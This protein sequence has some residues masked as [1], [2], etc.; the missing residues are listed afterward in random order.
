MGNSRCSKSAR[1]AL[2]FWDTVGIF[3]DQ[4]AFWFWAVWLVAFPVTSWFFANWLTLRLGCLTVSDTV[5]LFTNS[6]TLGAIKHFATFVRAF[7]FTLRFFTFYIANCVFR[8]S[9]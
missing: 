7:N 3:T 9:T 8:F 6:N 1:A 5:G 2:N 4:L